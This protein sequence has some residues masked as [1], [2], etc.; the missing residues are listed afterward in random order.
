MALGARNVSC[1]PRAAQR[2]NGP[3]LGFSVGWCAHA[4]ARS[5]A[6]S[7][8]C[9]A[10]HPERAQEGH[11]L[12]R[13][14][15]SYD[16]QLPSTRPTTIHHRRCNDPELEHIHLALWPHDP[17]KKVGARSM[18]CNLTATTHVPP[19]PFPVPP[20]FDLSLP[21]PKAQ[22]A[23]WGTDRCL[24]LTMLVACILWAC[25]KRDTWSR[26][27]SAYVLFFFSLCWLD[28]RHVMPPTSGQRPDTEWRVMAHP[29]PPVGPTH[30]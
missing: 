24:R 5:P 19:V 10:W 1:I 4:L 26:T 28:P 30:H 20:R 17:P 13:F 15:A 12:Q 18:F 29:L 25:V 7:A 27:G 21:L 6:S 8:E 22:M 16:H 14:M 11:A 23:R 2:T 3:F 9:D